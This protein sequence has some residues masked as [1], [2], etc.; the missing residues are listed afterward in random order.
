MASSRDTLHEIQHLRAIAVLLVI[1]AHLHQANVRFFQES[2]LGDFAFI[3]FAGVDI[4]FVV[5]GFIIHHLYGERSGLDVRFLLS[6]VNRIFP[7]YWV[8]TAIALLGYLVM[9]DSLESDASDRNIVG[10]LALIPLGHPPLL[11]VGWT[12]THELYFY[13]IYG[14]VL[15]LPPRF[16]AIAAVAWA[17]MTI[18]V[19]AM[20]EAPANPWI[21]L[22]ASP[23]NLL[24]LAGVL[25]AQFSNRLR[26]MRWASFLAVVIATGFAVF[27]AAQGGFD[28][29]VPVSSRVLAYGPFAIAI[30]WVFITWKPALPR[31]MEEIGDASYS[32]YLSHILVISVMARAGA[33]LL[34]GGVVSGAMFYLGTLLACLV[35]GMLSFRFLERRL[36]SGGKHLIGRLLAARQEDAPN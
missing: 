25:L 12:L 29:F 3:G 5:S 8:F 14:L 4:F 34:G 33:A 23:F 15:T 20:P 28:S 31:L 18:A 36:L 1:I 7:L 2:I 9:G 19:M 16:R 30:V 6:R 10:S 35:F 21:A 22:A 11:S 32:I 27:T 24:F 17:V 13:L 26:Q